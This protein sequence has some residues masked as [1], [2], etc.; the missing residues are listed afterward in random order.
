VIDLLFAY[1]TLE[2]P[3][4]IGALIGRVPAAARAQLPGH[5]RGRLSGRPYPGLAVDLAD[6]IDGTLYFGLTPRELGL[7]DRYEGLEYRRVA[8]YLRTDKR[9]RR[10]WVYVQRA[11]FALDG[12]WE[13][14]DRR[15]ESG[16]DGPVAD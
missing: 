8:R 1:G 12:P 9:R 2:R 7:L 3:E 11:R 15:Q 6:A 13:S 4:L 10:G 16:S 5:R 14:A